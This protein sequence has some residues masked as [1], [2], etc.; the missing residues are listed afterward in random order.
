MRRDERHA[1][2]MRVDYRARLGGG[3]V[4]RGFDTYF[5]V[6][7]PNFAP[8]TWFEN[9]HLTEV[10]SMEKPDHLYGNPG[11]AVPGW[12]L[13]PMIPEFTRR[14]ID[15]IESRSATPTPFYLY[16]P[17][18]SPHSPVVPNDE[19]KGRSG[20]GNCGDVVGEVAWLLI[21]ALSG[22]ENDEPAWFRDERGYEPHNEARELY[23]L[24]DDVAERHNLYAREPGIARRLALILERAKAESATRGPSSRSDDELTE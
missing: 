14:A 8:Y 10:P 12:R 19:L 20:A 23:N 22:D 17:L 15:Y 13:E 4:D 3:P 7:V 2:G 1:L 5:G 16:F 9:D 6:D 18:T 11:L 24:A 21:D